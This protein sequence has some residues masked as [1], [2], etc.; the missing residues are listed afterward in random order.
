MAAD[1]G[2]EVNDDRHSDVSE[3]SKLKIGPLIVINREEHRHGLWATSE[4]ADVLLPES[5]HDSG[6]KEESHTRCECILPEVSGKVTGG[7]RESH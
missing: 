4:A 1:C 3:P 7:F 6:G 5:Q 2:P